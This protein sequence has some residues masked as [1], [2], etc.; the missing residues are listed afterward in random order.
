[1]PHYDFIWDHGESG[2]VAH[3]AEHGVTPDEAAYVVEH[4][5]GSEVNRSGN[6]VAFGFTPARRHIAVPHIFLDDHRTVVYV[7]TAYD[8]PARRGS[9]R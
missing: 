8:A 4:P 2:N 1:M 3:L 7:S 5:T 9:R 6:P